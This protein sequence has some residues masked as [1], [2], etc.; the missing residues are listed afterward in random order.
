MLAIDDENNNR[1]VQFS[2]ADLCTVLDDCKDVINLHLQLLLSF[3]TVYPKL[4][5]STDWYM[6]RCVEDVSSYS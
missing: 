5:M 6:L 2:P 4:T 1:A 3:Q